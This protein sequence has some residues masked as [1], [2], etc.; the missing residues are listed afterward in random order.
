MPDF[1]R[2]GHLIAAGT[3]SLAAGLTCFGMTLRPGGTSTAADWASWMP[4]TTGAA[5]TVGHPTLHSIG[6][7]VLIFCALAGDAGE[8]FAIYAH[9]GIR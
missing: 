6:S 9:S 1:A 7:Q 4:R 8:A 5:A 3:A 2:L